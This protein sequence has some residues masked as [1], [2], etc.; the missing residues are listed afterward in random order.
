V[1]SFSIDV[2]QNATALAGDLGMS[3][4]DIQFGQFAVSGTMSLLFQTD[5]DYRN[6]HTGSSGGTAL[7]S[8]I[9]AE[10]LTITATVNANLSVAFVMSQVEYTAYPVGIDVSGAPIRVAVGFRARPQATIANTLSIV[11]K[12]QTA[13]Y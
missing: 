10:S 9:F 3:N 13:S 6:F 12:N 11:T 1:D 2:N 5:A 4:Y 8:T 7:G